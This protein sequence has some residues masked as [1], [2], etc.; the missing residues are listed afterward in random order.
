MPQPAALVIVPAD[1]ERDPVQAPAAL[2]HQTLEDLRL[3]ERVEQALLRATGYGVFRGIEVAVQARLVIL[4]GQ[5]PSYYMNQ[6]A[7]AIALAVP[8]AHEIRNHLDVSRPG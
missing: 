4:R 7:Q 8:G 2:L 6:V 3:A 5:V 1:Q